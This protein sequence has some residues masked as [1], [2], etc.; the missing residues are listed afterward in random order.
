MIRFP[1]AV[2]RDPAVNVGFFGGNALA[3]LSGLLEARGKYMRHVTLT[4]QR[5]LD[6]EALF[7]LI[8]TAHTDM[9]ARLT[10]L[11]GGVHH[12]KLIDPALTSPWVQPAWTTA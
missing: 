3:D 6:S 2:R 4:P 9:R 10:D 5:E 12:A 7:R 8:R 11:P 1:T